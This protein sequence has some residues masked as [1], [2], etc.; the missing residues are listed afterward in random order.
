MK[1]DYVLKA[2]GDRLRSDLDKVFEEEK[3]RVIER[4]EREKENTLAACMLTLSK[5]LSIETMGETITLR[6]EKHDR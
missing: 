5:H 2:L 6:I 1:P 4:L 3:L